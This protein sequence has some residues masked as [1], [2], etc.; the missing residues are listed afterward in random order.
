MLPQIAVVKMDP[1][2]PPSDATNLRNDIVNVHLKT[3]KLRYV[4]LRYDISS[5]YFRSALEAL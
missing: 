1:I 5:R 4:L 2:N 3:L